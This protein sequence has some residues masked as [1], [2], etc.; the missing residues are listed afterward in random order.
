MGSDSSGKPGKSGNFTAGQGKW[1]NPNLTVIDGTFSVR[2][3]CTPVLFNDDQ[4][5]EK[6][7]DK[8]SKNDIRY[9]EDWS[10]CER[11]DM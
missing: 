9:N 11:N 5:C 1:G 8:W 10:V 3:Q 2:W 7:C 4:I 6:N